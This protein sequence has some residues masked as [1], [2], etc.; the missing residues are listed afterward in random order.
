M[1]LLSTLIW[2]PLFVYHSP[3][4]AAHNSGETAVLG[5]RDVAGLVFRG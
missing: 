3:R 4:D 5:T 2:H 1:L